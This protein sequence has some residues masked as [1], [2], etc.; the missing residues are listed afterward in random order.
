MSE[1]KQYWKN[2]NMKK[3]LY[4]IPQINISGMF[5]F[6]FM[7]STFILGYSFFIDFSFNQLLI[8]IL[9]S[10]LIGALFSIMSVYIN[11][12]TK[13]ENFISNKLNFL[14]Q[15]LSEKNKII[16]KLVEESFNDHKGFK[17]N[18]NPDQDY[19]L[20]NMI[21]RNL[22]EN[23][24]FYFSN[25][26]TNFLVS[27]QD[28]PNYIIGIKNFAK[29]N[30]DFT[31]FK[32]IDPEAYFSITL[33][34]YEHFPDKFSLE[35]NYKNNEELFECLDLFFNKYCKK[36]ERLNMKLIPKSEKT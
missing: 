31:I 10:L 36:L 7:C 24:I 8:V 25:V 26:E 22:N 33:I 2:Y 1:K 13:S 34:P 30:Y 12:Y 35:F 17:F 20:R 19:A 21:F 5:F 16:L 18:V 23:V 4:K 27:E 3:I 6:S 29:D 14:Q 11:N 9:A 15:R 32:Q 28:N